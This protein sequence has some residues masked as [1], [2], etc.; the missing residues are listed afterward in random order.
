[1]GNTVWCA[2]LQVCNMFGSKHVCVTRK[3]HTQTF[4][5][6]DD[7]VH[8]SHRDRSK[9]GLENKK[10][11]Q[12]NETIPGRAVWSINIFIECH[13]IRFCHRSI[14]APHVLHMFQRPTTYNTNDQRSGHSIMHSVKY[15]FV[16]HATLPLR[17]TQIAREKCVSVWFKQGEYYLKKGL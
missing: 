4:Q 1:M 8:R 9:P 13:K 15:V 17:I 10:K 7:E 3:W 6:R 14:G 11:L 2:C 16:S 5:N 12:H